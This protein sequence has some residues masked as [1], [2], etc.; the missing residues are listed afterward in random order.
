MN[1][2][3]QST[4]VRAIE[5]ARRILKEHFQSRPRD[6]TR[7]LERVLAV[8]DKKE[9]LLALDRIGHHR[10]NESSRSDQTENHSQ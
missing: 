3:D 1:S 5:D 6:A 4:L 9:I 10:P 8:L 7:T 2:P